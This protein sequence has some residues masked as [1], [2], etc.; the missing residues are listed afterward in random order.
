M[1]KAIVWLAAIL[2]M[3]AFVKKYHFGFT[4]I[5]LMVVV[6]IVG[7]LASIA[8]PNYADYVR[9]GKIAEATSGLAAK[10]VQIEQWF[11]DQRTYVGA[12]A[13]VA[14]AA[15]SSNF[16]FSCSD[17]PPTATTYTIQA[18]GVNS[19]AGFKFTVN[20][21]NNRASFVVGVTGW[22][23]N[24]GCWIVRSGGRCS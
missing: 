24:A 6:A 20:E 10:R 8:I 23:G 15:T 4:L 18:D 2:N 7:I 3:G 13:C 11:Q 22:V 19:M 9:R 14:D 17:A 16:T 5:E 1:K 12:P 21:L